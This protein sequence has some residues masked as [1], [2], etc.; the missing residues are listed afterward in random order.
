MKPVFFANPDEMR[1]VLEARQQENELWVGF[2]KRGCGR[3]SITW[4]E[5]V[6]VAL[7]YG[8]IDGLRKSIDDVRYMIRFTPRRPNSAW[9]AINMRRVA[10]LKKAGRMKP[11]GLEAFAQRSGKKSQIYSYEQRDQAS[12]DKASEKR[13]RTNRT[14]WKFFQSQ[15]PWYKRTSTY[16]VM[17]AKKE[18]TRQSRLVRLIACSADGLTLPQLTRK[19]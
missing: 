7:C 11:A 19:K 2:Y 5:S 14:A 16:W 9:S 1:A 12:F 8:W 6:D 15:A 10:E 4:P 3:P 17:T 13:F 18:E